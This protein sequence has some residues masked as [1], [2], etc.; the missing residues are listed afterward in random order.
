MS[1]LSITTDLS[2]AL[3]DVRE[4][5]GAVQDL[6]TEVEKTKKASS[7]GSLFA[8]ADDV[9][10]TADAIADLR[11]EYGQ[12][13]A[14]AGTL[15]AAMANATDPRAVEQYAGALSKAE[16]AMR[17]YETAAKRAGVALND[18][19]KK[20]SQSKEVV[21]E[22]FSAFSKG[23]IILTAISYIKQWSSE[24]IKLATETDKAKKQFEAFLGS[25]DKAAG[26]V[27]DLK[28]FANAKIL[29]T[30]DA[31]EAGK[32]LLAFGESADNLTPVLSR[33]LDISRA[34]GKN[35]NELTLIYGKARTQGVLYAEDINQLTEA[36]IPIIQQFAKQLGVSAD[37][38]K[39]LASEG[40]IGFA[41]L[42]L[43][44]AAMTAEGEKFAGQAEAGIQAA[45]RFG[46]A[47]SGVLERV[48][49]LL[50]PVVDT[51]ATWAA[52]TLN[53]VNNIFDSRRP[54]EFA[55]SILAFLQ[56]VT[57]AFALLKQ[58][59]I[60]FKVALNTPPAGVGS[61]V[62]TDAREKYERA[63]EQQEV[64]L[65]L[66]RKAAIERKKLAT[67]AGQ[68]AKKQAAEI[69]RLRIEGMVE[70]EEK[71][72]AAEAL[73]YSTLLAQLKKYGL[74]TAGAT[75][76]Y[77]KNIIEIK[78]KYLVERLN[79]EQE[80]AEAQAEIIQAGYD[81]L[82]AIEEQEQRRR[83]DFV[84]AQRANLSATQ[85]YEKA[86]FEGRL[87]AARE[88]FF[89]KQRTDAEIDRYEKGVAKAR[90]IF[91]LE[92]QKREL[93]TILAYDK[94][95]GGAEVAALDQR[96]K[97]INAQIDQIKNSVGEQD[98]DGAGFSI[99]S[100][101]GVDNEEEQRSFERLVGMT[102]SQLQNLAAANRAAADEAVKAANDR[103]A[104]AEEALDREI[105][106]AKLGYSND[107]D[108][109][110][111]QLADAEAARQKSIRQQQE[112]ARKQLILESLIQAASLATAA[113]Q[114]LKEFP[115]PLIPVG[116][117]L[118]A[119]MIGAFIAAKVK[120]GNA[121]RQ[122]F[123]HGGE[124]DS[125]GVISGPS[126]DSGGVP[127]EA[128][129]GEFVTSD[130]RRI[131]IVNKK[132][133]SKH[134]DLIRAINK[135]DRTAMRAALDRLAGGSTINRAA[136]LDAAG[137]AV[138]FSDGWTK[139]ERTQVLKHL[140]DA[141]GGGTVTETKDFIIER[142]PGLTRKTRKVS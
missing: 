136:A 28:A 93:E 79:A 50:K 34:T 74:D 53:A 96:I 140:K 68:D 65:D 30:S 32:A 59:G 9:K 118:V 99:W 16:T 104:S 6:R 52:D 102:I 114:T 87:L 13:R 21:G 111:K 95:L 48:G 35:F 106:L 10:G 41:E 101:L 73:R 117:A 23:A 3:K 37:K 19:N 88:A 38:V 84:A 24:A 40:K 14:A 26:K 83:S 57:P 5:K 76:Q 90:E 103:V 125:N 85:E 109:R 22:L 131:S 110:R 63:K 98:G 64:L 121:S 27:A 94:T 4:L 92:Q 132:M 105:E 113:A 142:R 108:L 46:T 44:F 75:E 128:E 100:A 7:G 120:A 8:G 49:K 129:G 86:A 17:Q 25:A 42:E 60:D 89:S 45:D 43:A 130:G 137:G 36:G 66:E 138:V 51:F 2:S 127:F 116:I 58:L 54:E 47:W 134:F 123:R 126:H 39:K 91:T 67:K 115:G 18:T 97:N 139:Y 80:A 70:G 112:A 11:R 122:Q 33:I 107:V 56:R 61:V 72:I 81:D 55:N 135:D 1:D 20:T 78:L 82:A 12:L 133:T 31:L 15:R 29:P 124:I 71:E 119:A 62:D 69:A 77:E 141:A